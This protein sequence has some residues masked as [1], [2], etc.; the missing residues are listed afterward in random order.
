MPSASHSGPHAHQLGV[1]HDTN[2]TANPLNTVSFTNTL[3][4]VAPQ[5]CSSAATD[6]PRLIKPAGRSPLSHIEAASPAPHQGGCW[7][8]RGVIPF[9]SFL[10]QRGVPRPA[11]VAIITWVHITAPRPL[12]LMQPSLL[13]R[14]HTTLWEA[15]H[16]AAQHKKHSCIM[17]CLQRTN[18]T[19]TLQCHTH[20]CLSWT[21]PQ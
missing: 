12:K 7:R 3:R 20:P 17:M 10:H 9:T 19:R 13:N 18:S 11:A 5:F 1:I 4:Q 16:P 14:T 6:H 8:D 15:A 21:A 2:T